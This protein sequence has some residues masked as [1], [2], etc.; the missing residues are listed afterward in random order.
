MNRYEKGKIYKITDVGY[1]KCYIG[2]TCETL[3]KRIDRHRCCYRRY[4]THQDGWTTSFLLFEEFGIE[5]CKIELIENYPCNSKEELVRREGHYIKETECVNKVVSGRTKREYFLDNYEHLTRWRKEYVKKY[6]QENKEKKSE[7]DKQ[8]YN[9][10]REHILQRV[11]TYYENNLEQRRQYKKNYDEKKKNL[12]HIYNND[13]RS[14]E[15]ETRTDQNS[16]IQ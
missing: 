9:E 10:K 8:R 5:N 1:N 12:K 13:S 16:H 6:N 3:S 11:K 7:Y 15:C 2:S 4:L 14:S